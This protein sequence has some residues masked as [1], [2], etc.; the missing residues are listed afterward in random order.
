MPK[1]AP[2]VDPET[3]AVTHIFDG[4]EVVTGGP[5]GQTH[6]ATFKRASDAELFCIMYRYLAAEQ[7]IASLMGVTLC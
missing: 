5:D 6:V 1:W 4:E 7:T 2:E 3:L